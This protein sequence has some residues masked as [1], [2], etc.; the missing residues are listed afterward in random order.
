M[1]EEQEEVF[2]TMDCVGARSMDRMEDG[3]RRRGLLSGFGIAR[4]PRG[5]SEKG[6]LSRDRIVYNFEEF[7]IRK[8]KQR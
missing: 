4:G 6:F 8:G 3:N 7:Q 2:A 1:E 5:L